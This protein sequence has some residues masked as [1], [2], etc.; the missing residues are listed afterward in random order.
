MPRFA[1]VGG[2]L[3]I[4]RLGA[5]AAAAVVRVQCDHVHVLALGHRLH[6]C[7]LREPGGVPDAAP[8]RRHQHIRV[9]QRA[10]RC[11]RAATQ[12]RTLASVRLLVWLDYTS[13]DSCF[14]CKAWMGL[15]LCLTCTSSG[16]TWA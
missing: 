1:P 16:L 5:G 9:E 6:Q 11:R 2:E 4:Q 12:M 7:Q 13:S 10:D 3:Q 15:S 8:T 14:E